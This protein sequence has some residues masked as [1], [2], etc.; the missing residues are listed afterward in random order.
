MPARLAAAISAATRSRDMCSAHARLSA[1]LDFKE[2]YVKY[3][4]Q[5]N[6]ETET[7]TTSEAT[8]LATK[9]EA[10]ERLP[11][12]SFTTRRVGYSVEFD[13]IPNGFTGSSVWYLSLLFICFFFFLTTS[14]YAPVGWFAFD[15]WPDPFTFFVLGEWRWFEL[16]V[17]SVASPFLFITYPA[18]LLSAFAALVPLAYAIYSRRTRR[19]A[20]SSRGIEQDGQVMM[21]A[22][23]LR[24]FV[25]VPPPAFTSA[26][27]HR[28]TVFLPGSTHS[29]GTAATMPAMLGA[30]TAEGAM[31]AV[32]AAGAAVGAHN[33]QFKWQVVAEGE[34]GKRVLLAD[35]MEESLALRIADAASRAASGD[36]HDA[37]GEWSYTAP[38]YWT[39]A[40]IATTALIAGPLGMWFLW[41]AF[42]FLVAG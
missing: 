11:R 10:V 37:G 13:I 21:A 33:N 18:M 42:L 27:V 12:G 4:A 24:S 6:N 3:H 9:S 38:V 14:T 31:N 40:R 39:T 22:S 8:N 32:G 35:W 7:M 17:M 29:L 2:T 30:A 1:A 28:R 23:E 41:R 26:V 34:A 36:R 16:R 5:T 19:F 20:V 15:G 25:A